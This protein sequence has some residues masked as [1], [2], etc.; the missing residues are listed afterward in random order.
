MDLPA[1][2]PADPDR[3]ENAEKEKGGKKK[4]DGDHADPTA[5]FQLQIFWVGDMDL[6]FA[7]HR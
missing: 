6:L 3:E 4:Q 5:G 7:A 1:R 2:G